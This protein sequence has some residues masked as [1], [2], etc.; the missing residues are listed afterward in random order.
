MIYD[1]N[2]FDSST[3]TKRYDV[4]VCGAGVAGI[5]ISKKLI[6]SNKE[7]LLLEAGGLDA[8]LESSNLYNLENIGLPYD[9][10]EG[11]R[12]RYFGGTSNHWA[13]RCMELMEYDFNDRS[14]FD[15]PCWPINKKDLE[16]Y[17][18]EACEVLEIKPNSFEPVGYSGYNSQWFETAKLAKS[19]P[20]RFGTRY[21]NVL[22]KAQNVDVI[23]NAN[24]ID[25]ILDNNDR[26][27]VTAVKVVNYKGTKLLFDAS[28]VILC[29]GA[30]ENARF[31]LN[32]DHQTPKG[33][34]N[35]SDMLGRC[36]MEHF[37]VR[38]GRYVANPDIPELKN[39]IEFLPKKKLLDKEQI[40]SSVLAFTPNSSPKEYGRLAKLKKSARNYICNSD[41]F[42][43][44][45]RKIIDFDCPGDGVID[46][47]CEQLPNKKSRIILLEE[48]DAIGLRKAALD[49]QITDKDFHTIRAL[50]I[51]IAKEFARLNLGRV[52][53]RKYIFD[54]NSDF[55]ELG[56]HCH[57]M[58]TTRMSDDPK[59]GVVDRDLRVH[60]YKNLYIAGSSVFSTGG[61]VNPTF[62]IVQLALR[63]ADH[64]SSRMDFDS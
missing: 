50:G 35:H 46:T 32:T 57:Q 37:N 59:Y 63:L 10:A 21:R 6:A 5:T 43:E 42:L 54:T 29:F 49:W 14:Y 62:T 22:E 12:L 44:E 53:L 28:V 16:K 39:R 11:C 34:G 8:A 25:L 56:A 26:N 30:I 47:L 38:L 51:N 58:G 23:L 24:V 52:Q 40:G 45:A 13:G 2:E 7:V 60:G 33:I 55:N 17:F 64:I 15:L 41:F 18:A 61:G 27:R 31:L 48:K 36:F 19:P 20:T 4:I 3:E 9:G 1:L